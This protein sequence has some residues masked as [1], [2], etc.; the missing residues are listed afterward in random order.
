MIKYDET[1]MRKVKSKFRFPAHVIAIFALIAVFAPSRIRGQSGIAGDEPF[2]QEF[3]ITAYYSPVPG[4]CCYVKGGLIADR[5][6]NGEGRIAADGTEVYPGM[7]AA[8]PSYPFGMVVFLP[9]MGTFKVHDRGG[10]IQEIAGGVHRLDIWAGS[11]EGGLA[12]A[13][14]FGVRRIKGTVYPKNSK[15][16]EVSFALNSLPAFFERL[17]PFMPEG[18]NFLSVRPQFG[19]TGPSVELLQDYLAS[20]GYS[21]HE[22][23]GMFDENTKRSLESFIKDYKLDEPSERLTE[24]TAAFL[25]ASVMRAKAQD[26]VSGFVEKGSGKDAVQ[27]AQRI[28][29]F[30]DYYSGRTNGEYDSSLSGSILKF[31]QDYGLV[32]TARDPGAG[33]IGPITKTAL[34]TVWNRELVSRHAQD[35]LDVMRVEQVLLKRGEIFERFLAEGDGWSE[36][37]LLQKILSEKGLFPDERITGYFGP[38]TKEAVANYQISEG[39]IESSGE[40]AAGFVGPRTLHRIKNGKVMEFYKKVR[41]EGWKVL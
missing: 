37:K 1:K 30:L 28:L 23:T 13:L 2:E 19:N 35:L 24:R 7:I 38:V 20:A 32:G 14:T 36:V 8:P 17:N 33:R 16:P 31:Q 4:Q 40:Q 34:R 10:A 25:V 29:R 5:I 12:R 27:E 21:L 39:L 26:P 9:G 3:L 22:S 6:L 41:G 11:G 15:A 18:G